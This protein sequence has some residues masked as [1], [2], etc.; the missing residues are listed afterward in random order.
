MNAAVVVG[1]GLTALGA[2]RELALY[3]V[4][5]CLVVRDRDCLAARARWAHRVV[6]APYAAEELV[7]R[8]LEV[9]ALYDDD[10]FLL[11]AS[12]LTV[13]VV[14]YEQAR[15]RPVYRFVY[16][17]AEAVDLLL[18]KERSLALAAELGIAVPR[19]YLIRSPEDLETALTTASLPCILKPDWRSPA[20]DRNAAE[21]VLFGRT[22]AELRDGY[23]QAAPWQPC[24]VL[25]E[26]VPGG[27]D[28]IRWV[29]TYFDREGMCIGALPGRKVRQAPPL[30]GSASLAVAEDDPHAVGLAVRYLGRAG[31]RGLGSVEFKR[32]SANGEYYLMEPTVGRPDLFSEIAR[33]AG[34]GLA[35]LAYCD[36]CDLARPSADWHYGVRWI[37]EW[38]D[39]DSYRYYRQRGELST[40]DWLRSWRGRRILALWDRRRPHAMVASLW[41]HLHRR[42]SR[43]ARGTR[44][45]VA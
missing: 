42:L 18:S 41:S 4:P 6:D 34:C 3:G 30:C 16:P 12:D 32:S 45:R 9:R 13:R 22:P 11:P 17:S 36:A 40:L 39:Y 5:V 31:L 35:W 20:F 14:A 27:D 10:P 15:L 44:Q 1:D 25:Q 38:G 28:A 26:F 21:K 29:L 33:G 37:D 24:H 19:S 7:G 2:T 8:L 23:R 43:L